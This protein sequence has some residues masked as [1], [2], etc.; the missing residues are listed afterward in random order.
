MFEA[1]RN[2]DGSLP[3]AG[4]GGVQRSMYEQNVWADHAALYEQVMRR[5]LISPSEAQ[6]IMSEQLGRYTREPEVIQATVISVGPARP[7]EH[8]HLDRGQLVDA[9]VAQ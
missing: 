9:E 5:G 2:S 3:H 6:R 8:E 4:L 1:R 7:C